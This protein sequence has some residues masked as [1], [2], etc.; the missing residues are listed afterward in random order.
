M[1]YSRRLVCLQ[2]PRLVYNRC[3]GA[4]SLMWGLKFRGGGHTVRLLWYPLPHWWSGVFI[5]SVIHVCF[6]LFLW[7]WALQSPASRHSLFQALLLP[8]CL[9]IVVL[10]YNPLLLPLFLVIFMVLGSAKRSLSKMLLCTLFSYTC[11]ALWLCGT[12]SSHAVHVS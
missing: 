9:Y 6:L 10:V 5:I 12:P 1:P 8:V 4:L 7:S 3:S 11:C 2:L